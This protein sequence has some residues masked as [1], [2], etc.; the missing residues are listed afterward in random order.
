MNPRERGFLLLASHLGNPERKVLTMV[1]LRNL[2]GRIQGANPPEKERALSA[3]DLTTLGYSP[4][5]ADRILS[6]LDDGPLLERYLLRGNRM[7]CVP[8]TRVS[9]HYPAIVRRR[10]GLDSPGCLWVKGDPALLEAPGI[11]LVGS[12]ELLPENRE[13]AREVGR[14]AARQGLVLV[15]GNARGADRAA[16]D[17]CLEAGGRV[18]SVVADQLEHYPL[19]SRITYVSEDGFDLGFSAQR[20]LSRNRVIHAL[21]RMVFVAQARLGRGGTWD[22]VTRN[23]RLNLSSVA[24]FRDGSE[25]MQELEQMGAF[26]VGTEDLRDLGALVQSSRNITLPGWEETVVTMETHLL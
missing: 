8:V 15:S 10:L 18:V 3:G 6:L 21:G 19:R 4:E 25:A 17:A 26:L 11:A 16:Q 23:L 2:A 7:D 22:G 24:C 20:A 1:Q 12:R 9:E 5:Q 13:F 14:Q